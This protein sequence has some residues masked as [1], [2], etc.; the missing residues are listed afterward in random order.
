MVRL[1]VSASLLLVAVAC[2]SNPETQT[3]G[4]SSPVSDEPSRPPRSDPGDPSRPD[5]PAPG[6]T[7]T[8]DEPLPPPYVPFDINHVLSTGQSNAVAIKAVPVLSTTQ[9][10]GNLMFDSGVMPGT[11]CDGDGCTVYQKPSHF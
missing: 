4:P 10:Y 6:A 8:L 7:S 2:E 9:P 1:R 11:S 5:A 3:S